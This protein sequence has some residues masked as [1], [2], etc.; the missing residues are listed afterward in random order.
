MVRVGRDLK[1]PLVPTPLPINLPQ[2]LK[3][4]FV[5][6]WSNSNPSDINQ[7]FLLPLLWFAVSILG[8]SHPTV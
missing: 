5:S 2:A 6:T 1:D 7:I 3:V 8:Q 4:L